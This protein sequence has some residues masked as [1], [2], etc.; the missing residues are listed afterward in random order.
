[1]LFDGVPDPEALAGP[2]GAILARCAGAV[3][4]TRLDAD[5]TDACDTVALWYDRLIAAPA[6]S[7]NPTANSTANPK[8][9]A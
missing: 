7:V 5:I 9:E 6:K 1:L 2:T 8:K 4:F 3:D